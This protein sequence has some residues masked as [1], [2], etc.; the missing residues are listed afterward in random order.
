MIFFPTRTN[1]L[2]IQRYIT[3]RIILIEYSLF[4]FPVNV[5]H[6]L[7]NIDVLWY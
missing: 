5:I 3:L 6:I 4:N 7:R 2:D 1:M